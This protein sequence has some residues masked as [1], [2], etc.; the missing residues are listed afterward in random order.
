[1]QERLLSKNKG[2][3]VKHLHL[4][5]IKSLQIP[6]PSIEL[7]V[8]FANKAIKIEALKDQIFKSLK[9]EKILISSLENQA[10]TTGFNA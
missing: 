1:M 4:I 8:N 2:V 10:F 7:Q 5:D 9:N 6:L 3:G